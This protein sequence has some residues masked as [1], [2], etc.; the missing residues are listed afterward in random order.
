MSLGLHLGL[1]AG[2][3]LPAAPLFFFTPSPLAAAAVRHALVRMNQ[4]ISDARANGPTMKQSAQQPTERPATRSS[5]GTS[6]TA[7]PVES[8]DPVEDWGGL[9]AAVLASRCGALN[10]QLSKAADA[11][12][13]L[14]LVQDNEAILNSVNVATALHRIASYLKTARAERDRVLRDERFVLLS[15]AAVVSAP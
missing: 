2:V 15:E 13:V 6:P 14:A 5:N 7:A 10:N 3:T 9:P 1:V 4:P 8:R 12:A 11:D